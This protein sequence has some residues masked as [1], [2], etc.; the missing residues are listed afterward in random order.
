MPYKVL[1]N[2][3]EHSINIV[4]MCGHDHKEGKEPWHNWYLSSPRSKARNQ[5]YVWCQMLIQ[6]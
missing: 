3:S 2:W 4:D 1:P 6:T 5:I